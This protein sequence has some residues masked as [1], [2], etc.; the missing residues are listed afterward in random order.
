MS[1]KQINS[2]IYGNT[3]KSAQFQ[4]YNYQ[5]NLKTTDQYSFDQYYQRFTKEL[6]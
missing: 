5:W 1:S 4:K 3:Q 2:R 6:F